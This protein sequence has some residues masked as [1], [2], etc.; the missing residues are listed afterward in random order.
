MTL[1]GFIIPLAQLRYHHLNCLLHK[2]KHLKTS[3]QTPE[4]CNW[5]SK[6]EKNTWH[7]KD[8]WLIE[9]KIKTGHKKTGTIKHCSQNRTV[10]T[11]KQLALWRRSTEQSKTDLVF[12]SWSLIFFSISA[13]VSVS[14]SGHHWSASPV[15]LMAISTVGSGFSLQNTKNKNKNT[16]VW[17]DLLYCRTDFFLLQLQVSLY[18]FLSCDSDRMFSNQFETWGHFS[19]WSLIK[20]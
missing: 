5:Y 13:S 19:P 6:K 14:S 15:F 7:F 10:P 20:S 9:K 16:S 8:K 4:I 18:F 11:K 17:L 1:S 12:L 3:S 2:T